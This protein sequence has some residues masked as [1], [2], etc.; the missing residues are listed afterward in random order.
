MREDVKLEEAME[1]CDELA[2]E[3]H[4]QQAPYIL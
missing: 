1:K 2:K 3:E 4:A